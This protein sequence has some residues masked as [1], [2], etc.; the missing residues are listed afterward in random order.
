MKKALVVALLLCL[1]SVMVATPSS[2]QIERFVG[3][4]TNV[5]S[6][7]RGLVAVEI[8]ANG[9][10]LTVKGWGAC[11]PTPCDWGSVAGTAYAP[12]VQSNLVQTADSITAT[13]TTSFDVTI[14]VI[15]P[16][17]DDNLEVSA[18][19]SFTDNSGRTAYR[20]TGTFHR[21]HRRFLRPM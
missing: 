16:K 4:W 10:N 15:H 13:F 20:E 3:H 5:N 7:T 6:A 9:T 18:Y 8:S 19:T 21:E 1:A 14:L 12:D 17:D 11:S 2:A